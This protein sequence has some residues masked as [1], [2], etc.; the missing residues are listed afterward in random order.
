MK[1]RWTRRTAAA[2]FLV[3]LAAAGTGV[4]GMVSAG[5]AAD[6]GSG[7]GAV[8]VTATAS[9]IRTPFY[10]SGGEDVEGQVPWATA[11]MVTGG[12]THALTSMFWPGDTRGNRGST[13]PPLRAPPLP[14]QPPRP[15]PPPP[16]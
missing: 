11:S 15:L 12:Q 5:A 2:T 13:P 3:G 9:G 8:S 10:S 7:L 1:R 4:A 14:P 16:P 6:P